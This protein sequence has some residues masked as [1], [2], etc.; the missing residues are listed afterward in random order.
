MYEVVIALL[1]ES[2]QG[3]V[4]WEMGRNLDM[5]LRAQSVVEVAWKVDFEVLL[6]EVVQYECGV[7]VMR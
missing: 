2:A 3:W 5:S 7:G 1:T 4:G 6:I